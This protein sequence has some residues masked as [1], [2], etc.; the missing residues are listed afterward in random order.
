MKSLVCLLFVVLMFSSCGDD[1]KDVTMNFK[2]TYDNEPLV[3]LQDY[4]YPDGRAIRFTRVSFFLSDI[5]ATS[6]GASS[7][8]LDDA[9][10]INMTASNDDLTGA[11]AGYT[12]EIKDTPVKDINGI[13]FNIGLS[14]AANA[15]TPSDFE[16]THPLSNSGEYW[17]GWKSYVF[18]K[19]EGFIDLDNNGTSE[20]PFA[21]HLGSDPIKRTA[22]F[23][24][25][26]I[27][28]STAHFNFTIDVKDVFENGQVYDIVTTTNIHSL[29]QINQAMF[30]IDNF[31]AA[32][33]MNNN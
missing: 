23:N 27:D 7:T 19:F 25:P 3:M 28:G 32:F 11:L 21:L 2:L 15:M 26:M 6:E 17:A 24:N 22:S 16:P 31:Q 9:V 10:L 8:L 30:L 20:T 29:A 18:V 4:L 5:E 12:Y 13:K 33:V 1:T 14:E